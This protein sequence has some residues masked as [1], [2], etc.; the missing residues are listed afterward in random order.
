MFSGH[1]HYNSHV[2]DICFFNNEQQDSSTP[3]HAHVPE[4]IFY[5]MT[6]GRRYTTIITVSNERF[7]GQSTQQHNEG[8]SA[9]RESSCTSQ[10]LHTTATHAIPVKP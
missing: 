2:N 8:G 4:T 7:M 3:V 5:T 9:K 1:Y 10:A 6:E